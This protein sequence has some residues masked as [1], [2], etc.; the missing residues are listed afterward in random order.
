MGLEKIFERTARAGFL[1][2]VQEE[3]I[4]LFPPDEEQLELPLEPA[5][6]K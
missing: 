6:K 1:S 4:P 3:Q 5:P 2:L